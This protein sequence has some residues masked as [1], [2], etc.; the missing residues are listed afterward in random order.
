MRKI[1]P[2]RKLEIKPTNI[3][4]QFL[5]RHQLIFNTVITIYVYY[6]S[7]QNNKHHSA[8][9]TVYV[10][11]GNP[12]LFQLTTTCINPDD[13]PLPSQTPT[14]LA[15]STYPKHHDPLSS[16][17][18]VRCRTCRDPLPYHCNF[19]LPE[20]I[21]ESYS[22]TPYAI[23]GNLRI[24][25]DR[26]DKWRKDPH[27]EI[28]ARWEND[29]NIRPAIVDRDISTTIISERYLRSIIPDVA[30]VRFKKKT[31]VW[32]T[33]YFQGRE[34]TIKYTYCETLV[35]EGMTLAPN[36]GVHR[37]YARTIRMNVIKDF[38]HDILIGHEFLTVLENLHT[39]K[40][41][42]YRMKPEVTATIRPPN[43][44]KNSSHETRQKYNNS[45][46]EYCEQTKEYD[47]PPKAKRKLRRRLRKL[48]QH[49]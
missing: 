38:P 40:V 32:S 46:E 9:F 41:D 3:Q 26:T 15:Q 24:C 44:W 36:A 6:K 27:I 16:P 49:I 10:V 13:F 47:F 17:N 4:A 39:S 11:K 25:P 37:L 5:A 29:P 42:R 30:D 19:H 43:W 45:Y 35:Y 7:T 33:E 34:Y 23:K 1:H 22:R 2:F 18:I 48:R 8:H 14:Q 12:S 31:P 20:T 21:L 28:P